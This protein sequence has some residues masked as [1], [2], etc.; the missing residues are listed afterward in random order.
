M[1]YFRPTSGQILIE[2]TTT[3]IAAFQLL[4][5]G[6]GPIPEPLMA[7]RVTISNAASSIVVHLAYGAT[8][9]AANLIAANAQSSGDV[10]P[11]AQINGLITFI[12]A[13]TAGP[14][15]LADYIVIP[16]N[17]FITV[18]SDGGTS[19]VYICP[20]QETTH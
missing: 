5:Q 13:V 15:L 18:W 2:T 3:P 4:A 20:G 7:V 9:V 11:G 17:S 8:A 6:G 19:D 14:G 10:N 12:G 16:S 1:G